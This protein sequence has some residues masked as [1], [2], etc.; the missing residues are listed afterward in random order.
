MNEKYKIL[1][2][3]YKKLWS[4]WNISNTEQIYKKTLIMFSDWLE[5]EM[6]LNE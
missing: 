1:Q 4:I 3:V 6:K 2:Q 5:E